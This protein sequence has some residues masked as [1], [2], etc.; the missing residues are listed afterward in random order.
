[1][2]IYAY[3]CPSADIHPVLEDEMKLIGVGITAVALIVLAAGC[4]ACLVPTPDMLDASGKY[5]NEVAP[6]Y[7]CGKRAPKSTATALPR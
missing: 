5:L 4:T 1:M 2:V 3:N 6:A 7:A